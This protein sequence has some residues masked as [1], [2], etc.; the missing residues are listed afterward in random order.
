MHNN[1]HFLL[2]FFFDSIMTFR[3]ILLLICTMLYV[4]YFHRWWAQGGHFTKR[5]VRI[6]DKVVLVTGCNTGIGKETVLELAK[7]GAKIY[8]ACRDAK[9]C[10]DARID[11]IKKTGNKNVFNRTLDLSSLESIRTFVQE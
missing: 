7:R 2:F 3:T 11:I 6:N 10:E 5:D 1:F 4:V 8:M 9:R